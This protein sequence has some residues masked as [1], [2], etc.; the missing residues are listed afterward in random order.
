M[1]PGC[2]IWSPG[3]RPR[4]RWPD[5]PSRP[6]RP[7]QVVSTRWP[8]PAAGHRRRDPAVGGAGHHPA[9]RVPEPHHPEVDRAV[10]AAFRLRVGRSSDLR[11]PRPHHGHV[12]PDRPVGP[13]GDLAG[14]DHDG[15][16]ADVPGGTGRCFTQAVELS[17]SSIFTLGTTTDPARAALC[18]PTPK[19][20]WGCCWWPCSSPTCPAS[21]GRSP[22]GRSGWRYCRCGPET[23]R[24]PPPCS[25]ATTASRIPIPADRAVAAV[26]GLV[27]GHRGDPHHL[28]DPGVLPLPPTGAFV[29]HLGRRP[30]RRGQLLGRRRRAPQGPGRAALHPGR[31]PGPAAH[32]RH[33]QR[34]LRP[35][36]GPGRPHQRV[37][38][39]MGRGHG[40][41]GRGRR[42]AVA[43]REQAWEAWRGWRVNYDTVLLNLA[44][45]VEAPPTPWVSDRSPL[46]RAGL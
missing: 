24:R 39:R 16:H 3:T 40:R 25:S 2:E 15:L 41:D 23:R 1:T 36:S 43:D 7:V 29:D 11:T 45:L 14:P 19:P 26:G 4:Y 27:R 38:P 21:T 31:L 22:A 8:L 33:L 35:R 6:S 17:G 42:T 18:S 34:A 32:R 13:A 12:R 44:R 28:P 10:R 46:V 20:A 9:P 30:P 37:P 5:R